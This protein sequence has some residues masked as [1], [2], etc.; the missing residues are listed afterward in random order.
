MHPFTSLRGRRTETLWPVTSRLSLHV[1]L[2]SHFFFFQ[3]AS[4]FEDCIQSS[5]FPVS[6]CSS[7]IL[8]GGQIWYPP[9]TH[10]CNYTVIVGV[11]LLWIIMRKIINKSRTNKA[12][13]TPRKIICALAEGQGG[14]ISDLTAQTGAAAI[15]L[16]LPPSEDQDFVC[17]TVSLWRH[18]PNSCVFA[19]IVDHHIINTSKEMTLHHVN[20]CIS[21]LKSGSISHSVMSDSLQ[22]HGL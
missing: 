17:H 7:N 19:H 12:D 11:S 13:W 16:R 10:G 14:R 21:L 9:W 3:P 15:S 5:V 4:V 18:L 22:P 6:H 2:L 8:M 1:S 20:V